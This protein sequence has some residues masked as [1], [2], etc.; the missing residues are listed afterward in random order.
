MSKRDVRPEPVEP[1]SSFVS[2]SVIDSIRREAPL[3]RAF[4]RDLKKALPQR[5]DDVGKVY[6]TSEQKS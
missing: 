1:R 6:S 2:A 4:Q 3:D 5:V